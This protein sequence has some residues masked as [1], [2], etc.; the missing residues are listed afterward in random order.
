MKE[1]PHELKEELRTVAYTI[2]NETGK[3][4]VLFMNYEQKT[5]SP[6]EAVTLETI[7]LPDW[8]PM[9]MLSLVNQASLKF[10]LPADYTKNSFTIKLEGRTLYLG[11]YVNNQFTFDPAITGVTNR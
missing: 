3:T 10:N 9:L 2:N 8:R 5:L 4:I 1:S 7:A 11:K 6:G